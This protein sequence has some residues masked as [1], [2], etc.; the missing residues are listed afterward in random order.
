MRCSLDDLSEDLG[1]CRMLRREARDIPL[2]DGPA[3]HPLRGFI[4]V[5]VEHGVAAVEALDLDARLATEPPRVARG[6]ELE[7]TGGVL[8]AQR[9]ARAGCADGAAG[10]DHEVVAQS[11]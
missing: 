4:A 7:A 10:D 3:Q 6:D 2:G 9:V 1:E 5:D 11:L 8:R